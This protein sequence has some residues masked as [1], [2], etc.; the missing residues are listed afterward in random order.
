MV[1]VAC[2]ST[3]APLASCDFI[4]YDD[5]VHTF[6]NPHLNPT[7]W[8]GLVYLWRHPYEQLYVPFAYTGF[9]LLCLISK[10]PHAERFT[11][12][13]APFNPHVFH[14][15]NIVL[16]TGNALFLFF[17]LRRIVKKDVPALVGCLL[18]ALHPLQV[19][20]VA[21][22][23]ELRGQLSAM[24]GFISLASYVKAWDIVEEAGEPLDR[25]AQWSALGVFAGSFLCFVLAL[26]TKP[27]A[28][29]YPVLIPLI[30]SLIHR[31]SLRQ[32]VQE[33]APWALVS[34]LF[35]YVARN[36]QYIMHS[37]LTAPYLRP[38][39]AGDALTFYLEK[40]FAPINLAI[41]YGR[42]PRVVL[43]DL[44]SFELWIIPAALIGLA[45][46]LS[47]KRPWILTA[48]LISL[49]CLAP[50]L[51]L[52]PFAFQYYS[53]VTDRYAY[54]AMI[55][56]ALLVAKLVTRLRTPWL[57]IV[58]VVV[59]A[60]WSGLS[61]ARCADWKNTITIMKQ[62]LAVNPYS[63]IALVD[64][65][66][67]Y[68]DE[69]LHAVALRAYRTTREQR[70]DL[71]R[72][73]YNA[74]VSLMALGRV[75]EAA[76]MYLETFQYNS[77]FID[78]H[79]GL[80]NA[81]IEEGRPSAALPEFD[82]SAQID[83]NVAELHYGRGRAYLAMKEYRKA[84][85]EFNKQIK[86]DDSLASAYICKGVVLREMGQRKAAQKMLD[87]GKAMEDDDASWYADLG[88]AESL[89]GRLG[90]A[91]THLS[92][93]QRLNPGDAGVRRTL[94]SVQK[95][96]SRLNRGLPPNED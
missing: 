82:K 49:V 52:V 61:S 55:G 19:E 56:P 4:Q 62:E 95:A 30:D 43:S 57:Y 83:K 8:Q 13:G 22:V 93:A 5:Q 11:Q 76:E 59:L 33:F 39:I 17:L 2:A 18:F 34:L 77:D 87:K 38:F 6:A 20:S 91:N 45:F 71:W 25:R 51:G 48:S 60:A 29:V 90:D 26:L 16:H 53:T 58:P 88:K 36:D 23:S 80:A 10:T 96:L 70:P 44:R 37:A 21:W 66:N 35:I 15:A 63:A 69:G 12:T 78:A 42:T 67:Y 14:I 46:Y 94:A 50:N 9:A 1:I 74:A 84:L 32:Y 24:L 31:R 85:S 89:A 68:Q 72:G 28:V 79:M 81:L 3:F 64:V 54:L 92:K 41:D 27:T 7:T 47:R 86:V 40:F 75:H 73:Y 65:G